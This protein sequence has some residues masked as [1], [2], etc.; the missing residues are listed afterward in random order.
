MPVTMPGVSVSVVPPLPSWP[1]WFDPQQYTAPA[2]VTAHVSSPPAATTG[3]MAPPSYPPLL[4]D[5]ELLPELEALLAPDPELLPELEA[6]LA[7]DPELLPELEALL[8]PDPELLT[9]P[10]PL[11]L[12][13]LLLSAPAA[14][15]APAPLLPPLPSVDASDAARYVS[16]KSTPSS[17]PQPGAESAITVA[18]PR[19]IRASF[20]P[21][22]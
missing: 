10:E 2:V 13:T 22:C 15:S 5:P 11:P 19:R 3:A 6:L 14:P 17:D 9:E 7:P 20:I 12:E 21:S 8:P 4:P 16:P 1:Y 18:A